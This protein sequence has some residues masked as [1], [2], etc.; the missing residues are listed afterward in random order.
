MIVIVNKFI[1]KSKIDATKAQ[2]LYAGNQINYNL[3][4]YEQANN[5]DKL[6]NEMCIL[7][8]YNNSYIS[9]N[10]GIIKSKEVICPKCKENCLISLDNYKIRLYDCKN[11]HMTDN[12]F[13]NEFDNLQNI[14]ENE[15]KCKNCNNT[16]YKTY[17]KQFYKCFNCKINLCPLCAQNHDKKHELLD[18]NN[19]NYICLN[20]KDFYVSYCKDCKINLCMKCETKHYSNH[21]IINFK[22][23]FPDEEQIKKDI[24]LFRKK[25]D[26]FKEKITELI[27][28]LNNV[29]RN[30]EKCYGIIYNL[31][32]NYDSRKR[33]YEI[34][35]NI[36]YIHYFIFTSDIDNINN[37][38]NNNK[39]EFDN[40]LDIYSKINNKIMKFNL[41][42]PVEVI[43][44]TNDYYLSMD[45]KVIN[46]IFSFKGKQIK[47]PCSSDMMLAEIFFTFS[48]QEKI[49]CDN[50]Q[51]ILGGNKL[52]KDSYKSLSEMNITNLSII[53]VKESRHISII[54]SLN[55][56]KYTVLCQL[57]D[58]F[59]EV[60]SRFS[61]HVGKNIDNMKFFYHSQELKYNQ[62]LSHYRFNDF[63]N[64]DVVERYNYIK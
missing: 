14:N 64:I 32:E 52:K 37:S 10:D 26:K 39:F 31:L 20:H 53:E 11:G 54:F 45:K 33:N 49:N 29:S 17:N 12:I 1:M 7:V 8:Y 46:L 34:L 9:V 13:L 55:G 50:L 56:V 51:F 4:F 57:E 15:I 27:Q 38:N 6:R 25:I 21:E 41:K 22:A 44:R 30:I 18:Y 16:K 48:K 19:I 61:K 40:I 28:I 63:A 23:I 36:N 2:F 43:P 47:I 35:Q 58:I 60:A 3:T 5:M 42:K 62:T 59:G 24:K